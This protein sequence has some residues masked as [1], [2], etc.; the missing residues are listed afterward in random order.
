[1]QRFYTVL[2][3]MYIAVVLAT[4]E[5]RIEFVNQA[6]CDYF[7]FKESPAEFVG[8]SSS[9]LVQKMKNKYLYPDEAVARLSEIRNR[10]KPVKE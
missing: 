1:M 4:D 3:S 9:D 5:D 2:S 8:L 10:G 7:E 6:F